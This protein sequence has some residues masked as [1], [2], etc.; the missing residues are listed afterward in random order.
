MECEAEREAA[1]TTCGRVA[2]DGVVSNFF[3]ARE[4]EVFKAAYC[5]KPEGGWDDMNLNI[6]ETRAEGWSWECENKVTN[7][8]VSCEVKKIVSA[9]CK[10]VTI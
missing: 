8:K 9:S 4:R 10:E 2:E 7:E 5:D 6:F 3:N 1:P